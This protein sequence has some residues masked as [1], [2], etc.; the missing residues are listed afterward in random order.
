MAVV[1]VGFASCDSKEDVVEKKEDPKGKILPDQLVRIEAADGVKLR[2]TEAQYTEDGELLPTALEVAK[3]GHILAGT[4]FIQPDTS[5]IWQPAYFAHAE[6]GFGDNMR[7]TISD[8][9]ALLMF[10]EDILNE[11]GL[12][13][14]FLKGY[15][16]LVL[17][18][19]LDT[20]AYIPNRVLRDAEEKIV[21][22]YSD[23]NYTE[24]YKLFNEAYKFVPTT[25]KQY[26][27][28]KEKG[29]Q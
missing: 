6:R 8:D 4:Y 23:S 10:S 7:D 2:S 22:A 16:V 17:D 27:K 25:G 15:D 3:N 9:P 1:A 20:I 26:R 29:L 18:R 19:Q 14:F 13:N 11:R 24:V 21:K 28:L 5:L 12:D